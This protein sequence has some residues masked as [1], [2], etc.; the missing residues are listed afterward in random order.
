MGDGAL[1]SAGS[2]LPVAFSSPVPTSWCSQSCQ[3][4]CISKPP[5]QLC[6][7]P[8]I[9]PQVQG[10]RLCS[11]VSMGRWGRL[12]PTVLTWVTSGFVLPLCP[13]GPKE[14]FLKGAPFVRRYGVVS[15]LSA[16][17]LLCG[18]VARN[19]GNFGESFSNMTSRLFPTVF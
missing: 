15:V 6:G 17:G 1:C 7:G 19:L 10:A 8:F 4:L 12:P 14:Q 18:I 3:L 13:P 5:P 16:T 11:F 2:S 9:G